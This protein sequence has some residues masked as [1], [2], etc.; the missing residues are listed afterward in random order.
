MYTSMMKTIVEISIGIKLSPI[1]LRSHIG[2]V[3]LVENK[4]FTK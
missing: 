1:A 2:V 3:I 4:E